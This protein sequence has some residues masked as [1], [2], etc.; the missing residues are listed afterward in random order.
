MSFSNPA[1][2]QKLGVNFRKFRQLPVHFQ[3]GGNARAG[4]FSLRG[5]FEQKF[6]DLAGAQTLHQVIKRAVLES[7]V[8]TALRLATRQVLFDIGRA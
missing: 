8:A 2:A 7:P 3:V 4:L 5:S 1:P 6:S